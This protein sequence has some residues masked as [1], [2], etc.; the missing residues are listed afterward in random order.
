MS[1]GFRLVA[2]GLVAV[3]ALAVERPQLVLPTGYGLDAGDLA[4][5]P[6]GRLLGVMNRG[7]G[8]IRLWELQTGRALRVLNIGPRLPIPGGR[9]L[10]TPSGDRLVSESDGY[11]K[12]WDVNTGREL[13]SFILP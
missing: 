2:L 5:S 12:I 8:A 11:V 13:H 9:F 4:F 3:V 1:F 10:F 7:G 6:D